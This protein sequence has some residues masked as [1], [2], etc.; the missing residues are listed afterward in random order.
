MLVNNG[1]LPLQ[2]DIKITLA[3]REHDEYRYPRKHLTQGEMLHALSNALSRGC[4]KS[5]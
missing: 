3:K 1:I 2:L 4:I 5:N